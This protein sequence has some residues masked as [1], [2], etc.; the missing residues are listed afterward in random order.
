M[1]K[2]IAIV[3]DEAAIR[4]NYTAALSKQGYQVRAYANRAAAEAEF[5]RQLPDL[6]LLDIG[7]ED[8]FEGGFELCR[9]LRSRS[10]T[11]PIIFLTARDSDLDTISGLRLGADDYLTKD[12]SLANLC[13]RV[14][15]FFRRL[16]AL[17][18]PQ[19]P[20]EEIT[21]GA[22]TLDMNRYRAR[23]RNHPIELS[24]TEFWIVHSL[25][26]HPG[27]V[28]KR[29]QLMQAAHVVVDDATITSHVKRIRKK[30]AAVDPSFSAI[31]SIYAMGYR[32][33]EE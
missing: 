15:A 11:L 30:F 6:V 29:E 24:L 19:A 8:E 2:T 14:G 31:E 17:R 20:V 4:Q 22:L 28:K 25:A 32:W 5:T 1:N 12:I 27:H 16:E 7:L 23:W 3:E 18:R 10:A 33:N 13:A 26:L 9:A 21:R